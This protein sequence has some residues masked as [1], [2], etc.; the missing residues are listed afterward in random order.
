MGT[1]DFEVSV[2]GHRIAVL[3]NSRAA[4]LFLDRYLLLWLPRRAPGPEAADLTFRVSRNKEGRGF[5]AHAGDRLIASGAPLPALFGQLQCLIDE[6]VARS[7]PGLVAIH[8]G[9]V[10]WNGSVA[11]LPGA[12]QSGKTTLVAELLKRGAVYYSDEY[13]FLDVEGRVHA[14]PRALMVR[15]GGGQQRPRLPSAW[16]AATADSPAP[17]RLI[18]FIERKHGAR[19]NVR[20]IPQSE[21]LL[22]L[23][24]NTP[25]EMAEYPEIVARLRATVSSAAC[26]AGVRGEA[27]EAADR[28][29]ELLAGLE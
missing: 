6:K 1:Q 7:R 13:A 26:Y 21:A 23:L 29:I 17:A 15:N 27:G 16:K 4:R 14:Y 12:T 18:L 3:T 24:R 5:D 20:R 25:Q 22:M 8:A 28:V 19:R 9:V 11:L 2:F 10:G